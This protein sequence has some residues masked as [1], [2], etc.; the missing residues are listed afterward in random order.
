MTDVLART[1]LR[2][3]PERRVR[4]IAALSLQAVIAGQAAYQLTPFPIIENA[5]DIFAGD[6]GRQTADFC[7]TKMLAA[8][9]DAAKQDPGIDG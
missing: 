9:E 7:V 8:G 4:S 5:A 3:S 6:V 1:R 2:I